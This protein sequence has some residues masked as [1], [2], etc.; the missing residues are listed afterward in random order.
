MRRSLIPNTPQTETEPGLTLK[1]LAV[2]KLAKSQAEYHANNP[3]ARADKLK[4]LAE[5]ADI[6]DGCSARS[7]NRHVNPSPDEIREACLKLQAT[8][9]DR[10]A[11]RR[12]ATKAKVRLV[13][14]F[15]ER[16]PEAFPK[17]RNDA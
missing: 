1:H 10:E 14:D 13:L 15:A 16:C 4:T 7:T 12:E 5:D 6:A 17:P 11:R 2:R 3:E 9:T 8:W